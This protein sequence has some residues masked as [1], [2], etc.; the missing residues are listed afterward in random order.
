MR[1]GT[2]PSRQGKRDVERTRHYGGNV[3]GHSSRLGRIE[4]GVVGWNGG[5]SGI[6]IPLC[7]YGK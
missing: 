7:P 6:S 5:V 1:R 3:D 2:W 4:I